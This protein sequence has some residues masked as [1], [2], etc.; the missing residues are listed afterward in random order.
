MNIYADLLLELGFLI[1]KQIPDLRLHEYDGWNQQDWQRA[2]ACGTVQTYQT[3]W[4]QEQ[5]RDWRQKHRY[6]RRGRF[7]YTLYQLLNMRGNVPMYML[8]NVKKALPKKISRR[9][10]WG[11]IRG[12]LKQKGYVQ[13]YNRI[14]AFIK[15]TTRQ[16]PIVTN[17]QLVKVLRNFERMHCQFAKLAEKWDRKYF[18][19]MRYV[20]LKLLQREGMKFPYRVPM[21]LTTRKRQYLDLLFEEFCLE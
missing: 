16:A 10:I 17:E 18:F 12:I 9:F 15:F 13:F 14:P 7:K 3:D 5:E 21:L 4:K 19:S 20:C 11:T 8:Q 1:P 6:C 2:A